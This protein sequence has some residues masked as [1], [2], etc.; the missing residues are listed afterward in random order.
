MF[1]VEPYRAAMQWKSAIRDTTHR[2]QELEY[3]LPTEECN[4]TTANTVKDLSILL[5]SNLSYKNHIS[6]V[7]KTAF[8]HLTNI[9]KLRNI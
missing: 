7:I 9:G 6:Q 1:M 5:D 2:T 3:N 8:L 4:L